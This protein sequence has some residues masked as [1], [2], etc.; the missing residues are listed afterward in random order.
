MHLLLVALLSMI[1][2]EIKQIKI[3]LLELNE[4]CMQQLVRVDTKWS[5]RD[6]EIADIEWLCQSNRKMYQRAVY[7]FEKSLWRDLSNVS[8]TCV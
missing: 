6:L 3:T 2:H 5:L 1:C 4:D 7:E 8:K